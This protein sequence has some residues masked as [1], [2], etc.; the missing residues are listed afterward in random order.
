MLW[1]QAELGVMAQL[2]MYAPGRGMLVR[3]VCLHYLNSLLLP[4]PVTVSL[5]LT[6]S[7]FSFST[8]AASTKYALA[9]LTSV[10]R[11]C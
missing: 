6:R 10:S 5:L 2:Q 3:P 4:E 1:V 9:T 11:Y 7:A 8:I